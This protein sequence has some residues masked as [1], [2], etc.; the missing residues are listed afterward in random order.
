MSKDNLRNINRLLGR[1]FLY[2]AAAM[3]VFMAVYSC[4]VNYK[5]PIEVLSYFYSLF[6]LVLSFSFLVG[7]PDSSSRE[8]RLNRL[9]KSPESIFFYCVLSA[10]FS[11]I[12]VRSG[13]DYFRTALIIATSL[14]LYDFS[15]YILSRRTTLILYWINFYL[16][17]GMTAFSHLPHINIDMLSKYNPFGGLLITLFT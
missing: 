11:V 2:I 1:I 4:I 16:F 17:A 12:L 9:F 7:V 13:I 8:E 14:A 3:V 10:C 15:M 6:Y 5:F